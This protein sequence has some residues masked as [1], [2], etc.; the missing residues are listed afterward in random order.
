MISVIIP[1]INEEKS[2]GNLLSVLS[3]SSIEHEVI[4]ADGGSTDATT[5][6]AKSQ[7][8][9]VVSAELGRGEQLNEGAQIASGEI[10]W[11]L[12]ADSIIEATALDSIVKHLNQEDTIIGGNFQ[13]AYDGDKT[14]D[15]F[16]EN[17][18][19]FLR[20]FGLYYGDSGIFIRKD[21]FERIGGFAKLKVMEDFEF[22][23]RLESTGATC[24]IKEPVIISSSRRFAKHTPI[25]L[26]SL[27]IKMHINFLLG[28]SDNQLYR[29]YNSK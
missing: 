16:T 17:L 15:R 12:H 10:L 21:V 29:Q 22:V 13:I 8:A 24:Y 28:A 25:G 9:R 11:F 5:E 2:L 23:R 18:C 26:V 3:S 7:K 14:I 20:S 27:W 1:T 19:R 4:I 6:I